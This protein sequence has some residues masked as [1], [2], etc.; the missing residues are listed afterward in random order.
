MLQLIIE[1]FNYPE[2]T[3]GY[4]ENGFNLAAIIDEVYS[5][6]SEDN[7]FITSIGYNKS[8][9]LYGFAITKWYGNI[10]NI[11]LSGSDGIAG[12]YGIW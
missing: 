9:G 6:Y 12:M 5:L 8:L 11:T 7:N 4:A 3:E 2:E 10:D 1:E